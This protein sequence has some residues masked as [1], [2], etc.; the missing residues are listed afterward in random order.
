[1]KT[2]KIDTSF[3]AK[4]AKIAEEKSKKL[5]D[6]AE[7]IQSKAMV[8]IKKSDALIEKA[9][10]HREVVIANLRVKYPDLMKENNA[11]RFSSDCKEAELAFVDE[12]DNEVKNSKGEI[13]DSALTFS[14]ME[15]F[16]SFVDKNISGLIEG[17]QETYELCIDYL[18]DLMKNIDAED[19]EFHDY[20]ES[21]ENQELIRG[22]AKELVDKFVETTLAQ[23]GIE[24]TKGGLA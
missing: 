16:K 8:L 14:A 2:K 13:I 7:K 15:K 11:I 9:N 4:E 12:K 1:M 6:E 21:G 3:I 24:D 5:L 20:I 10:A 19:K 17:K 22:R 18:L 23:I